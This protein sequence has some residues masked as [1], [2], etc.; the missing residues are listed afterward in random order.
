MRVGLFRLVTP[1]VIGGGYTIE[2][3]IFERLLECAPTSKHE[4]VV[5]KTWTVTK[6]PAKHRT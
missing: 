2:H 1:E 3:E 5:L 6:R 4:F